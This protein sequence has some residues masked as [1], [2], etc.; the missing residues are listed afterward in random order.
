MESKEA[1]AVHCHWNKFSSSQNKTQMSNLISDSAIF[2][3]SQ[4]PLM[5][6]LLL[7]FGYFRVMKWF[8]YL[9]EKKK[10]MKNKLLCH[11]LLIPPSFWDFIFLFEKLIRTSCQFLAK[12]FWNHFK[13]MSVRN[14][15]LLNDL[16]ISVFSLNNY[17]KNFK[18]MKNKS[19]SHVNV[20]LVFRHIL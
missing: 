3:K 5:A 7:S 13:L 16:L 19:L 18:I 14:G 10:K 2:S 12:T 8:F 6:N 4:L 1:A 11:F 20:L 15:R 9:F 17:I